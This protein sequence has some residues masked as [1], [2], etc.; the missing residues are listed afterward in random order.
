MRRIQ[1]VYILNDS[2]D[3]GKTNEE[4]YYIFEKIER[5]R[6]ILNIRVCVCSFQEISISFFVFFILYL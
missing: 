3:R 5:N 2:E 4:I 6:I 1:I